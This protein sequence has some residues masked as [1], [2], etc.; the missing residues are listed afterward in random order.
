MTRSMCMTFHDCIHWRIILIATIWLLTKY[1][2]LIKVWCA[3]RMPVVVCWIDLQS[4]EWVLCDGYFVTIVVLSL[5]TNTFK[6]WSTC[7]ILL[8]SL[9]IYTILFPENCFLLI[10]I[11][12]YMQM[13][14]LCYASLGAKFLWIYSAF[15][16]IE[17]FLDFLILCIISSVIICFL[18][19]IKLNIIRFLNNTC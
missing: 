18:F 12:V 17:N 11:L 3:N 13:Y 6:F 7:C 19:W 5:L 10:M 8:L 4:P 15:P 1:F 9:M 16:F 14:S 2:L